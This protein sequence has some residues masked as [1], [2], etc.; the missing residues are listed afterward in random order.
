MVMLRTGDSRAAQVAQ[1][2]E[3]KVKREGT[4]ASW[5]SMHNPLLDIER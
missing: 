2:L 1:M 3:S 5:P 4:L